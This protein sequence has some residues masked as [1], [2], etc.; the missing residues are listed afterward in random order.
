MA[1]TASRL[2]AL[3][4]GTFDPIHYGHLKPVEALAKQV[5][6]HQVTIMPNNVP[7]HR[8]QPLANS[9][10]RKTMVELAIT[11][12]A[13]F[14]LDDREL[15]RETPSYTV[16]TL[17][18]LRSEIGAEQ[19]LAFIVGQDSLLSLQRWYRW[20]T[21]LTLCHLLV[22]QRPGY[23]LSMNTPEEQRWLDAYQTT[24]VEE[25]HNQPAGKIYL[26][27]TPMYD[28][29]ATAIRRR[30]EQHLPCDDLL[31]PAVAEFI[32]QHHLYC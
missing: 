22:C 19:P 9:E 31:P 23:S 7:P 21:L 30:L 12:N 8:S 32:R 20:E 26:A 18:Q 15:Q 3:Y 27:Q 5:A 11:G 13:L 6:L 1:K 10:Q 14:K 29:S 17:E 4:G 16:E 28:I 2:T 25:L 24:S